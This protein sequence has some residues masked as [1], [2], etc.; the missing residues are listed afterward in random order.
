M[1]CQV[2]GAAKELI[3]LLLGA[4]LGATVAFVARVGADDRGDAILEHLKREGVDTR[5]CL[6]DPDEQTSAT[7]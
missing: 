6:R 1:F 4:R 2:P 7:Y 3:R 5:C